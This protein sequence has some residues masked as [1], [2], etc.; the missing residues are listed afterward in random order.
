MDPFTSLGVATNVI[1]LVDFAGKLISRCKEARNVVHGSS[2]TLN[3][4]DYLTTGLDTALQRLQFQQI[5][6]P[7]YSARSLLSN[8]R[9]VELHSLS[10]ECRNVARE[11]L[12]QVA[13][14]AVN[15]QSKR[16]DRARAMWRFIRFHGSIE[17]ISARLD[18]YRQQL[19]TR[20]IVSIR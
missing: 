20:I 3:D 19:E 5:H 1:T 16:M 17:D 18:R 10:Q 4:I 2:Q 9:D 14:F 8:G 6:P 13:T 15:S 12:D 11:L 7:I